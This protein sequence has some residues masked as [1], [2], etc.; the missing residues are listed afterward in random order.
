[1]FETKLLLVNNILDSTKIEFKNGFAHYQD[2][3]R[4]FDHKTVKRIIE[5]VN[6]LYGNPSYCNE[7]VMFK[8]TNEVLFRDKL[9][10]IVFECICRDLLNS[11]HKVYLKMKVKS[12]ICTEGYESSPLKYL[13]VGKKYNPDEFNAKFQ[14][15]LYRAHYRRIFDREAGK[16]DILSKTFDDLISFQK[17]FNIDPKYSEIVSEVIVELIGNSG[18]HANSDCLIDID[19]A[20]DYKK[21]NEQ[22]KFL[23]MNIA[24]LNFSDR[25]LGDALR[26]KIL[27]SEKLNFRD[28]MVKGA[29]SFHKEA[30]DREYME[31]DFFNM[32]AFQHKISGRGNNSSTGGTGLT[33][34]I[35]SLQEKSD[36]DYCYMLSGYRGLIFYPNYLKYNQDDWL[37]FNNNND[38]FNELPD[39]DNVICRSEVYI[40]GTAYNL[41]FTMK[42]GG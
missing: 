5:F 9:V 14:S 10:I 40:P 41:N 26:K 25:L 23:G 24:I 8:F 22:G 37:G 38:F 1:M 18:E 2:S 33:K 3:S 30:F 11:G 36:A 29:Y 19:I 12:D 15:D 16:T 27:Y 21:Y 32:A 35:R 42:V 39:Y 13:C 17:P 34:L 20:P 6:T 4:N 28:L 31:E 7:T